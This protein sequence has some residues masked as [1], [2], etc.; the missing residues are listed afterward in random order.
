MTLITI[1][2]GSE[3]TVKFFSCLEFHFISFILLFFRE[4][5]KRKQSSVVPLWKWNLRFIFHD[6]HATC[7]PDGNV[8]TPVVGEAAQ[9]VWIHSKI[10]IH[11]IPVL[12]WVLI[13]KYQ[14]SWSSVF[15][16]DTYYFFP[17]HDRKLLRYLHLRCTQ[18]FAETWRSL[19]VIGQRWGYTLDKSL[20]H[21]RVT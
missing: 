21:H 11:L 16:Y 1:K 13:L 2:L 19:T 15:T 5:G 7:P 6:C 14:Y 20:V 17:H 12:G 10:S 4:K 3:Q 9:V 8:F 18:I